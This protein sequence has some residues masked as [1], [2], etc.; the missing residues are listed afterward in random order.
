MN[1]LNVE[2]SV[3]VSWLS[4]KRMPF[5]KRR[6]VSFGVKL[7]SAL[8]AF[9]VSTFLTMQ[10][11]AN[12]SELQVANLGTCSVESG[13]QINNCVVT[14]RVFGE[15]N[16]DASNIVL[17]PTWVNGSSQ[18][19]AD[20]NYLGPGGIVDTNKY[21]VIAIDAL[22]NGSSSSPS[23]Y[24]Q[25]VFPA[26][27]I[28]D[29]VTS[30]Y[31][32]VTEH[33]GL[34]RVHAVVGASMG[35]YQTYEWLIM[36]PDFADRFIPIEGTPWTTFYGYLRDQIL[37]ATLKL[38][39]EDPKQFEAAKSI[40]GALKGLVY[41]T[42][43]YL[44]R[45]MGDGDFEAAYS[46]LEGS[47]SLSDLRNALSHR[48]AIAT[49]DIRRDRPDFLHT[50][51]ALSGSKV[52]AVVYE[53]DMAVNPEPNWDFSSI[54]GF[55]VIEF[56]GD[57]GH[58]GPNPE[59]YQDQLIPIVD[60]FLALDFPIMERHALTV[61]GVE[62]EYFL[63]TPETRESAPLPLLIALHGWGST[64]TGFSRIYGLNNH[65]DKSG[66]AIAY[67]QGSNFYAPL[68]W[69]DGLHFV[70]SW[71]DEASNLTPTA[72]GPHCTVDRLPYPCPPDCGSC[73]HCGW[74][75]CGDDLTFVDDVIKELSQRANIDKERIYLLGN[76]NGATMA[77][78]YAC[79]NSAR[80]A[81]VVLLISQM[82]PGHTCGP[83]KA[84]PMFHYYGGLDDNVGHD[85]EATSDGW[86]FSSAADNT[87]VWAEHVGCRNPPQLWQSDLSDKFGWECS[88]YRDCGSE[89]VEVVSC[90]DP[91]QHHE[92]GEQRIPWIPANCVTE[93]QAGS[94]PGQP[95]C[96]DNASVRPQSAMDVFWGFISQY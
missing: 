66:Y 91:D 41:W 63:H 23:N 13:G 74:T 7:F 47:P 14:Y 87:R 86:I 68:A 4:Y 48:E 94:L 46:A 45:E 22:G 5:I 52:L 21:Q 49:H 15:R 35:A 27:S 53:E 55:E 17:M 56:P 78:R 76:S 16:A 9:G 26:I 83:S 33:M 50:V 11:S 24:D 62:R 82:P 58:F 81:G 19:L 10:T 95:L 2:V 96:P 73:N 43:D 64:A 34:E 3:V 65:A 8:L 31:R 25:D 39:L 90:K 54:L 80:V 67:L 77:Q 36:Y 28:R 20:S 29:M 59:C 6:R 1:S 84:L 71:N 37:L 30:Q 70:S 72:A 57:C 69:A 89:K 75:S 51:K 93:S 32:L 79:E 18:A 61:N 42:P 92:L 44:N 38:D 40:V 88:V 85:G 60:D 12:T